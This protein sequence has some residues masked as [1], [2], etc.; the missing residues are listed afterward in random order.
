[1]QAC[2]TETFFNNQVTLIQPR[3]GYRFSMDPVILS[4]Q[5]LPRPGEQILDIG[6]GAGIMPLILGFRN[7]DVRITGIEIQKE[8]VGLA[9]ENI[10]INAMD[11][12]I[13]ILNRDIRTLSRDEIKG[14]VH[15]IIA[16]P[17]YTRLGSGRINPDLQKAIA[18]HELELT[19][20]DLAK[21]LG[22]LLDDNGSCHIIYPSARK[23][24][25]ISE[26]AGHGIQTL[27]IRHIHP[28]IGR[29]SKRL[30]LAGAKVSEQINPC[31]VLPPLALCD[32]QG[33]ITDEV[34]EMFRS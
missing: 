8:L 34:Q 15:R 9:R 18:R 31:R 2:T 3:H 12:R 10:R 27:W 20:R 30:L 6:T 33:R 25:L 24:E 4:S 26:L 14:P 7:P 23:S 1:M 28:K 13:T 29:E 16:N 19:L 5:V 22:R 11:D 32:E 21:A 17:P